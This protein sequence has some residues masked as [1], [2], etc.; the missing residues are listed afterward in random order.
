MK[1]IKTSIKA[2]REKERERKRESEKVI[3]KGYHRE[4]II[5]N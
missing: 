3:S 2:V 1:E 5:D 4:N